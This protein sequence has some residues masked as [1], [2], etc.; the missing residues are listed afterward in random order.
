ML[1]PT[2]AVEVSAPLKV[3][4]SAGLLLEMREGEF[5]P[6]LCATVTDGCRGL[7]EGQEEFKGDPGL[8]DD[9]MLCNRELETVP[10]RKSTLVV[11]V[12][13]ELAER[14]GGPLELTLEEKLRVKSGVKLGD[15]LEVKLG[16]PLELTLEDKL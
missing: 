3:G 15:K 12:E 6:K 11:P 7:G 14:L 13:V 2:E 10:L 16:D 1:G 9:I 4:V 8:A 5:P